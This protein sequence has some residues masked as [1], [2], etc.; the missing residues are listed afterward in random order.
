VSTII[1]SDLVGRTDVLS[2]ACSRCD[3]TLQYSVAPLIERLGKSFSIPQLLAWATSDC[4]YRL[5]LTTYDLCGANCPNML[6]I[7]QCKRS[8][9]WNFHR[10]DEAANKAGRR[11]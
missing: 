3:K 2:I 5:S 9:D 1:L 8:E 11:R 4:Q 7:M 10:V 6:Q